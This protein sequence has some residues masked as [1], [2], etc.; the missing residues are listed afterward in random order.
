MNA[1][2]AGGPHSYHNAPEANASVASVAREC[3][4]RGMAPTREAWREHWAQQAQG[5]TSSH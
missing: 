4:K 2:V 1:A 5:A 3:I